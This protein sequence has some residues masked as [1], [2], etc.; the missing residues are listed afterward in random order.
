VD[1]FAQVFLPALSS[2]GAKA[3]LELRQRGY[4]PRGQG[5]VLLKVEPAE[6]KAAH[7]AK[8]EGDSVRGISHCSNLP[9]HVAARQAD[10]AEQALAGAGYSARI[11]REALRLPS[12]G[13]GITLWSGFKG[14]SSLG[15]RGL[16]A[17]KVGR[18]AAEEMII[19]LSSA[20]SVDLHLADQLI[21]YLAQAGGSYS[22][23][24]VSLHTKTNIW[25]MGH[26]LD[27]RMEIRE[28]KGA[29]KVESCLQ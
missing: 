12:L 13:S 14:T 23:R 17:E 26:F 22:V 28:E 24:E 8:R 3:C 4:Y 15:E 11:D 7:F 29:F 19:E 20:A 9:E 6:L 5:S 16:P 10:S 18:R 2:F 1:Y 27:S 21:V 25:T